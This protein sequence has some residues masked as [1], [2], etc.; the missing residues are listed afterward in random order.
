MDLDDL[1]TLRHAQ[2]DALM[3]FSDIGVQ[4]V[5]S[6]GAPSFWLQTS[7]L[8]LVL[9]CVIFL[10]AS[11]SVLTSAQ[12]FNLNIVPDATHANAEKTYAAEGRDISAR[13]VQS[14]IPGSSRR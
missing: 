14:N 3:Q 2:P 7:G 10:S 8:E 4:A 1:H 9:A 5:M 12:R 11:F 13:L 6:I